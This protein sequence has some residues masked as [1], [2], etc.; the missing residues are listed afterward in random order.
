MAPLLDTPNASTL[1]DKK[2][3]NLSSKALEILVKMPS[4]RCAQ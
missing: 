4:V 2:L 1:N 3:L